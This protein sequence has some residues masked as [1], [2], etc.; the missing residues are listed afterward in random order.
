[1]VI[2]AR[3]RGQLTPL[4]SE[5]L[6]VLTVIE[7]TADGQ[8]VRLRATLSI[9][10]RALGLDEE[11]PQADTIAFLSEAVQDG[12]RARL[13]AQSLFNQSLVVELVEIPDAEPATFGIF[14]Q[15][16]PLLPS[17]PSDREKL[18]PAPKLA[19]MVSSVVMPAR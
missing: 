4:A 10:P 9:D 18:A 5:V 17:V 14:A 13:A 1:M 7:D 19:T 15:D 2:I 11:S 6:E 3:R 12:L 8:E 16:A